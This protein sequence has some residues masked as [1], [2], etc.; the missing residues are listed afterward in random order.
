M[1]LTMSTLEIESGR[2][3]LNF[4]KREVILM[5]SP[6]AMG[7]VLSWPRPSHTSSHTVRSGHLPILLGRDISSGEPRALESHGRAPR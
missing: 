1:F 2:H 6:A 3:F 7:R 4:N 5:S